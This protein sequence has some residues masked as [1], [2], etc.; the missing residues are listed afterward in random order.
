M[1]VDF[2]TADTKMVDTAIA[3]INCLIT[4]SVSPAVQVATVLS[5]S[6]YEV[7]S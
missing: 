3:D 4:C 1:S 7:R 6:L 2:Q 5:S